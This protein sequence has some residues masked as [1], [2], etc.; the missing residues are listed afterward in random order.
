MYCFYFNNTC[1]I[2][3]DTQV[4]INNTHMFCIDIPIL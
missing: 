2:T 1:I 4:I 3:Y